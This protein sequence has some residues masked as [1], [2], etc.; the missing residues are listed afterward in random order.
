MPF[1]DHSV[2]GLTY[3]LQNVHLAHD[4]PWPVPVPLKGVELDVKVVNFTAEVKVTQRF[5][6]CERA[7]IECV[8]FFPVEE[9]AAVTDFTARLE[10]R[11]IKTVIKEKAEEIRS[12]KV[13]Y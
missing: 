10:G 1:Q 9:E 2:S 7:A 5:V 4:F 13:K 8:Y 12:G 3:L 11:T 6:N